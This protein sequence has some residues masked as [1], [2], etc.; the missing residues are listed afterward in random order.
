MSQKIRPPNIATTVL[1]KGRKQFVAFETRLLRPVFLP[2]EQARV[3]TRRLG[4]RNWFRTCQSD[5][6]KFMR[7]RCITNDVSRLQDQTARDRLKRSIHLD[8]PDCDLAVGN[9]YPVVALE[10]WGD[11][12]MRVYLHTVEERGYPYPYPLEMFDFVDFRLPAGW[13]VSF[14]RQQDPV[15]IKRISFP[16][17]T[18][19]DSFYEMLVDDDET[20]LRIYQAQRSSRQPW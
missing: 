2:S 18:N 5:M 20:V 1:P 16:E 12:G 9:V 13:C 17:W 19:S 11:D 3:M 15:R 4:R 10:S 8:G 6:E 7:V 14:A